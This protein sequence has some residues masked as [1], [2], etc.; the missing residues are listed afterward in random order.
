MSGSLLEDE[1]RSVLD[2]AGVVI[3]P[4]VVGVD[5]VSGEVDTGVFVERGGL[6][7]QE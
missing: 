7:G 3:V 6:L 4:K 2:E 1:M 5:I